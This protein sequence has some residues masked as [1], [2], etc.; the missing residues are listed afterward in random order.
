MDFQTYPR[1]KTKLF[2]KLHEIVA[3]PDPTLTH[4]VGTALDMEHEMVHISFPGI[5]GVLNT[6]SQC[7]GT[8]SIPFEAVSTYGQAAFDLSMMAV[9]DTLFDG[10]IIHRSNEVMRAVR[11]TLEN[12]PHIESSIKY[13]N[14]ANGPKYIDSVSNFLDQRFVDAQ[15]ISTAKLESKLGPKCLEAWKKMIRTN[16]KDIK[17][18]DHSDMLEMFGLRK[19]ENPD[20]MTVWAKRIVAINSARICEELYGMGHDSRSRIPAAAQT[21]LDATS[22]HAAKKKPQTMH[23]P[24]AAPAKQIDDTN[25]TEKKRSTNVAEAELKNPSCIEISHSIFSYGPPLLPW[26]GKIYS[27]VFEN[28]IV[29]TREKYLEEAKS[30]A[31]CFQKTPKNETTVRK[32]RKVLATALFIER[33]EPIAVSD[34]IPTIAKQQSIAMATLQTPALS[35]KEP[36]QRLEITEVPATKAKQLIAVIGRCNARQWSVGINSIILFMSMLSNV[37]AISHNILQDT[38]KHFSIQQEKASEL[39]NLAMTII[40]YKIS[41]KPTE[42]QTKHFAEFLKIKRAKALNLAKVQLIDIKDVN[43][44]FIWLVRQ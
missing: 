1:L 26:R 28:D 23:L 42:K 41:C 29:K 24:N 22:R 10:S 3:S 40:S 36:Q 25:E 33:V 37:A 8:V 34:P 31:I 17:T 21:G 43:E 4:C 44:F 9:R 11:T 20:D 12:V 19:Q 14:P 5:T 7:Y 32:Q 27:N 13:F 30:Y 6:Q 15:N 39:L 2:K 35:S 18:T 38:M 16:Y